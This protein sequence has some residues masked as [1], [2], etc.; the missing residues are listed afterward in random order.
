MHSTSTIFSALKECRQSDRSV[1]LTNKKTPIH[2]T[3]IESTRLQ[4]Q[5]IAMFISRLE[6]S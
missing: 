6:K 5:L 3:I 2:L 4:S 1:L